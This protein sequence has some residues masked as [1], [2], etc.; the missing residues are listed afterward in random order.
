MPQD[1]KVKQ[2]IVNQLSKEQYNK[3][4]LDNILSDN[5]LYVITD[6]YHYTEQEIQN[7]LSTKQDKLT[8][9][10]SINIDENN[11][12]SVDLTGYGSELGASLGYENSVLTLI[13]K[14]GKVL[15]N[16]TIKSTPD[17]DNATIHLNDSEELEVIGS[18]TKDGTIKYD[19]IGTKE[20]Y[21][22]G[23]TSGVI[24]NTTTCF[25]TNDEEDLIG[26]IDISLPTKL[27]E[28]S[29]DTNF[30]TQEVVNNIVATKVDKV[31]GK[32]LIDDTEIVR[33]SGITNYDDTHIKQDIT[34]LQNNKVDKEEGKTLIS[35]D[36]VDR[37]LA[38]KQYDDTSVV[39]NISN[40]QLNKAGISLDNLTPQGEKHFLNYSQVTNCITEIPQDIKLEL[41]DGVLTL[42]AGSKVYVPNGFEADGTTP[43]FDE[44]M[45]TKD[46]IT[47]VD[48]QTGTGS[49]LYYDK[50][51][52]IVAWRW[53]TECFSQ[54]N[55]PTSSQFMLWYDTANNI[56]KSTFDTGATW[57]ECSLTLGV[58]TVNNGTITSIDQIFNGFGYIG[59]TVFV[60]KGVKGLIPNG[61]NEDGTLNNIEFTTDRVVTY[62]VDAGD[63]VTFVS[64]KKTGITYSRNYVEQSNAPTQNNT[65]W[66]DTA[67]NKMK[68]VSLSGTLLELDE[69]CIGTINYLSGNITSFTTKQ[70]F[71][72]IDYSDKSIVS[73]W[74]MP[75]NKYIDLSVG[76]SGT[77]YTAPAN[78]WFAFRVVNTTGGNCGLQ[79]VTGTLGFEVYPNSGQTNIQGFVPVKKDE[80]VSIIYSTATWQKLRFVYAEGEQ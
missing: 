43:K 74:T 32:S 25:I 71:R 4:K 52:D 31:E 78:G 50:D 9:D 15:S 38:I 24:T 55:Q 79:P 18:L 62:T 46:Y 22:Q 61:R 58:F 37:L 80:K 21:E 26:E 17:T 5:E 30:I 49:I 57:T 27:S 67:N 11:V 48:G 73:S 51:L 53:S 56:I 60:T 45:I 2:L 3:A 72:A 36:E 34:S 40:L 63:G 77:T 44:V 47:P 16:V 76:A 19:W 41:N 42:K 7:I 59:S 54:T 29:N 28:L 23:L 14:D 6:D 33:L 10:G 69:V 39:N 70:P 13:S 35:Q 1:I 8:T 12:I 20:E 66:Y 75:S 64:I 65:L 68:R